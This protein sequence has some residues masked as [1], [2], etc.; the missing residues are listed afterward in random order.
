VPTKDSEANYNPYNKMKGVDD[1]LRTQDCRSYRMIYGIASRWHSLRYNF[2]LVGVN[3]AVSIHQTPNMG[4][5]ICMKSSS[6]PTEL[7]PKCHQVEFIGKRII[8]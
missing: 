7:R 2:S 8:Q 1:M 5:H 6:K 4:P 3:K